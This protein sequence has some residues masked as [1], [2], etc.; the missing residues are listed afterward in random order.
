MAM[1][2]LGPG[3]IVHVVA[4]DGKAHEPAIVQKV[5][6]PSATIAD[7]T[8]DCHVFGANGMR[9]ARTVKHDPEMAAGTWHWIEPA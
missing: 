8:I 9:V 2:G 7:G 6:E 5:L 3:R 1:Q 4:E